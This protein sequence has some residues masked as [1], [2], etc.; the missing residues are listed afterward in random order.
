MIGKYQAIKLGP[1]MRPSKGEVVCEGSEE[2]CMA[3]WVA[4]KVIIAWTPDHK[5]MRRLSKESLSS[6]R[7]KRLMRKLETKHPLF[8]QQ[9]FCKELRERPAYFA[10]ERNT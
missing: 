9:L 3:H 2:E 7:K 6:V 8:A 4:G 1:C 5:P 10:G